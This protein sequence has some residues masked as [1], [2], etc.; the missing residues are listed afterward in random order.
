MLKRRK[1]GEE[2][3]FGDEQGQGAK[4]WSDE[5]KSKLFMWLMGPQSDD[6]WASL[7][8]TKNSC[9]RDVS[10]CDAFLLTGF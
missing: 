6:H 4:H 10:S 9:L 8:A 5:E 7:R 1:D 3:S 2:E